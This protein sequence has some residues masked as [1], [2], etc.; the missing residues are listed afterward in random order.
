MN[1]VGGIK[2]TA[3]ASVASMYIFYVVGL[4]VWLGLEQ[5]RVST[6]GDGTRLGLELLRA[7]TSLNY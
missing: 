7:G 1:K 3:T 5:L 6:T 2:V 4:G